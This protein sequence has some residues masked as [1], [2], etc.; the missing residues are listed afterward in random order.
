MSILTDFENRIEADFRTTWNDVLGIVGEVAKGAAIAENDLVIAN[1]WLVNNSGTILTTANTILTL[2]AGLTG[3][4]VAISPALAA[5]LTT[6][7]AAFQVYAATQQQAGGP[8]LQAAV[9]AGATAYAQV[10]KA[11]AAAAAAIAGAATT[12][13]KAA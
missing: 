1:A 11:H 7:A 6:A 9:V 8:S 3:A 2:L 5:D 13:M 12:I 10:D 4:G